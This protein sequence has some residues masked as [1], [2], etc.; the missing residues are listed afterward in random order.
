MTLNAA[1]PCQPSGCEAVAVQQ[2][3]EEMVID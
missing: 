1:V 3:P 2:Q